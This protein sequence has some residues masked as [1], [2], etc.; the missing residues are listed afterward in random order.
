MNLGKSLCKMV[1]GAYDISLLLCLSDTVSGMLTPRPLSLEPD[2]HPHA[3][4]DF[5]Y[6]KEIL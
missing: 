5:S 2:F 4:I 1:E 6:F 3:R